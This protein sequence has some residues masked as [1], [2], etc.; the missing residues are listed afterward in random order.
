MKEREKK[1]PSPYGKIPKKEGGGGQAYKRATHE[2]KR[3][4][5]VNEEC[6]LEWKSTL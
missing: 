1:G 5:R 6:M 4:K 3:K 2:K